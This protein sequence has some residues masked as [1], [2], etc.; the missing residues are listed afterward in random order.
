MKIPPESLFAP[1]IIKPG[2]KKVKR[3][4]EGL[5]NFRKTCIIRK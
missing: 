2:E 3:R 5:D 4:M 1:S